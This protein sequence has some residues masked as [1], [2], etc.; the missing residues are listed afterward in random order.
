MKAE[1]LFAFIA[2]AVVG[3]AAAAVIL[4]QDSAS[5]IREKIKDGVNEGVRSAKEGYEKAKAKFASQVEPEEDINI[6]VE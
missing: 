3:A 5:E 4:S 2:G 1:S 6:E